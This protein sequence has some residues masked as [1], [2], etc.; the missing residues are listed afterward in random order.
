M[1][2]G[3]EVSGSI[4]ITPP[5]TA[6]ELR[7]HP[8]FVFKD[9]YRSKQECYIDVMREVTA[10]DEGE[11]VRLVGTDILVTSPD[12]SFSR[13][14][15]EDQLQD[16]V[17]EYYP[18]GHKFTGYFEFTGEDGDK[19]RLVVRDEKVTEIRPVLV[20]PDVSDPEPPTPPAE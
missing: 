9:D 18:L 8:E 14:N 2:Y 4:T 16:I 13:R 6:A 20:W 1:G 5:L 7:A 10:T 15:L 3:S 12:E 11:H 17:S 19:W